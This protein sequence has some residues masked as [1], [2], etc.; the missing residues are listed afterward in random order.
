MSH[1]KNL[2]LQTDAS[3]GSYEPHT[4]GGH[5]ADASQP[6]MPVYHRQYGNP[7]PLGLLAYGTVFLCASLFNIHS[8]GIHNGSLVLLFATFYAGITQ[9]LVG[10]WEMFLGNTFGAT[11]FATYGGFN[12]SYGALYL[13]GVGVQA[14][15]TDAN[16]VVSPDFAQ[17]VG[18]YLLIWDAIT[19]LFLIGCLR[20]SI[21]VVF[22]FAT[23]VV[24][25]TL[26]AANSF[27]GIDSLAVA[28]GAF[29]LG[30]AA[31]AYYAALAGF[32]SPTV[33]FKAIRLPPM[34]LAY[35]D[36]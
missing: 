1:E 26:L 29:G 11:V 36:V 8:R 5:V 34:S 6:T 2:N 17:A 23:T 28:G 21:P 22:T 12:L 13:P 25:L 27:T 19:L 30:A 24:S 18:I 9:I 16:G 33:T 31:G 35:P 10:M 32:Y 20:S 4:P 7:A 14:L 3:E 15:Y